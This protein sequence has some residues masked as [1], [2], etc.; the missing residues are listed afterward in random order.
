MGTTQGETACECGVGNLRD[1]GE[2]RQLAELLTGGIREDRADRDRA[3]GRP[4]GEDDGQA[5]WPGQDQRRAGKDLRRIRPKR[6]R[7][8]SA[9]GAKTGI[10][11]DGT[12]ILAVL[13]R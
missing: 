12:H 6:A 2:F 1:L 8:A 4:A 11:F 3:R 10:S 7:E 13:L 9:T 5:G